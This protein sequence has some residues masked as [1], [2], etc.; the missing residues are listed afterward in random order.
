MAVAVMAQFF[1][2]AF[3]FCLSKEIILV[4]QDQAG[5]MSSE[6]N[7]KEKEVCRQEVRMT[8]CEKESI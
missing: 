4:Y 2:M 3:I 1:R 5:P 8:T 7:V 6:K